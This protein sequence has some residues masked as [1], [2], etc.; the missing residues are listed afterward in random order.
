MDHVVLSPEGTVLVTSSDE[1]VVSPPSPTVEPLERLSF[2]DSNVTI[3]ATHMSRSLKSKYCSAITQTGDEQTVPV[4]VSRKYVI[5]AVREAFIILVS[6]TARSQKDTLALIEPRIASAHTLDGI[7]QDEMWQ[8][9]IV[10]RTMTQWC[11]KTKSALVQIGN[12]SDRTITLKPKTIVGAISPVTAISSRTASATTHN[13]SESQTRIDLTA[14]LDESFRNSAFN[15]QQKT[16]LLDLCTQYQ[17]VFSSTQ[18]E[19]GICTIIAEAEF[20]LQ[21]NTKPVDRHP[22]G[23]TQEHKK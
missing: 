21:K 13:H 22:Y 2:Q 4:L 9:L 18:E 5:S 10:A 14:A 17:S 15:D 3:P 7:P 6:S 1:I 19:L 12:P 11:R 8:T 20:P 23:R 16:Q